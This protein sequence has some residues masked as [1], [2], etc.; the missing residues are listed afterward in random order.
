MDT[1]P[2]P[3]R[4]FVQPPEDASARALAEIERRS[5][6]MVDAQRLFELQGHRASAGEPG[7][8]DDAA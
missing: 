3:R 1:N 5:R 8:F 7:P 4:R 2:K 6:V